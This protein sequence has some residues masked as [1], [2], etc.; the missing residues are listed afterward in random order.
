MNL[1]SG[2]T[3]RRD[4]RNYDEFN[5]RR[6]YQQEQRHIEA[7]LYEEDESEETKL[8][9]KI[10][11]INHKTKHLINLNTFQKENNYCFIDKVQ[12][13]MDL[14][15]LYRYNMDDI[16]QYYKNNDKRLP[17]ML[18]DKGI[19][20]IKEMYAVKRTRQENLIYNECKQLIQFVRYLLDYYILSDN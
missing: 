8:T 16:I 20:L 3:L 5:E 12:T 9:N 14:Y 18:Y 15:E 13:I 11:K 6:R 17:Q 4:S 10:K 19:D 2:R 7:T 1:R